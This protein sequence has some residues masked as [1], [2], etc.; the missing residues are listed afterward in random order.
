M[1]PNRW[2]PGLLRRIIQ[3]V[4]RSCLNPSHTGRARERFLR[5]MGRTASLA[6]FWVFLFGNG[7]ATAQECLQCHAT[8]DLNPQRS[9]LTISPRDFDNSVHGPLGCAGCHTD[10]SE[11]P[12][13]P[14]EVPQCQTC[15]PDEAD[16]FASSIHGGTNT[17]G[18]TAARCQDCHGP[19]HAI[20]PSSDLNSPASRQK[21]P[22][23]CNG[24]HGNATLM[25][26]FGLPLLRPLETYSMSVHARALAEGKMAA[27]CADCHGTHAIYPG[28]DARSSVFRFQVPN[29]CGRCHEEVKRVY[30]ESVHGQALA[31]GV[32]GAAVCTDC[33]GEHAILSPSDKTSP[34]YAANVSAEACARCHGDA[35]LNAKYNLPADQVR[36]YQESYHGLAARAG[37]LRVANCASCHGVHNILSSSDPRSTIAP[38]NLSKTCGQCHPG[39]GTR[40]AIG[41]VHILPEAPTSRAVYW[42]RW[43]YLILIPVVVG[44][45]FLHNLLD[46][47]RK[48]REKYLAQQSLPQF[49]R[50][51]RNE[52][53]QHFFLLTSF[54]LLVVS[55]FALKF[56]ESFWARPLVIWE[57]QWPVRALVHRVAGLVLMGAAILHLGYLAVNPEARRRWLNFLPRKTDWAEFRQQLAFNLGQRS[58]R[59]LL[60]EFSYIEKVEYWA[61]VWGT[62]LMAVTGLVLWNNNLTL[63]YLTK[64]FLD[65]GTVIHYYEAIL[66]TLAICVWHFYSVIFDPDRYPMEWTWITGKTDAEQWR[67]HRQTSPPDQPPPE[68]KPESE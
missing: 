22:E 34:V 67:K 23:T 56:P 11:Y 37:S 68:D 20:L 30:E 47:A 6:L 3:I 19:T 44:F 39:A 10:V 54:A 46:F 26:E 45:L 25:R 16:E 50:M 42:I 12:H 5:F 61:V 58:V 62:A 14:V 59:P 63:R 66:A 9:G 17:A 1:F 55:G 60:S 28:T 7:A 38:Q 31:H 41:P 49:P 32:T 36:S 40:L 8:P 18:R 21:L 43:F 65:V 57:G 4:S 13:G 51:N 29:T 64:W 2:C 53:W 15:H 24:C 48:T 35:R 27:N 33:H 52:R